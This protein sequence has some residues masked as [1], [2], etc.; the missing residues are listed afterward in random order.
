MKFRYTLT[1]LLI[2]LPECPRAHLFTCKP[3][4]VK[5]GASSGHKMAMRQSAE[6]IFMK[7]NGPFRFFR[8][9]ITCLARGAAALDAG[10]DVEAAL[11]LQRSEGLVDDLLV[12]L[13]P[14]IPGA[15]EIRRF[16]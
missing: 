6:R 16:L 15:G 2:W 5:D 12:Q 8:K 13:D 14:Y 1:T 3:P 7:V 9:A 10:D 4:S 11:E